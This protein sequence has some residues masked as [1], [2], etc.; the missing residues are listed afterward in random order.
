MAL[1]SLQ[2]VDKPWGYELLWARTDGYAAKILHIKSGHK[3]SLQY[4]RQKEETIFLQSGRMILLI[5]DER[6]EL[7]EV[8]L[9]VGQAHHIAAG[10][11]HRMIA[12]EDC[13]VFEVSTNHL[14]D[15][16][17]LEDSYGRA[18]TVAP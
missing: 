5:E 9:A 13:D 4:H 8:P 17:R 15:V 14:D 7:R 2:R 3:L 10:R 1:Q 6:D 16:V 11:R 12:I 18:G